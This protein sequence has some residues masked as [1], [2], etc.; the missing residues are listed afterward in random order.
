MK[1]EREAPKSAA[2]WLAIVKDYLSSGLSKEIFCKNRQLNFSTF[3]KWCSHINPQ[4]KP[5]QPIQAKKSN[6]IP[7]KITPDVSKIISFELSIE[8]PNGI[9][10]G[11]TDLNCKTH[12]LEKLLRVCCDVVNR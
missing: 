2:I 3:N 6:F 12:A 9:K 1:K 10:L 4:K 8:L 11:L 5:L 7:I